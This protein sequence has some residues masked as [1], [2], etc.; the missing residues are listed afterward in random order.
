MAG[1]GEEIFELLEGH[2]FC[3]L[4]WESTKPTALAHNVR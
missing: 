4:T 1:G 2:R 3:L